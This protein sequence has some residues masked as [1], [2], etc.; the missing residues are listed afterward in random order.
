MESGDLRWMGKGSMIFSPPTR[1]RDRNHHDGN[2]RANRAAC[3]YADC[4]CEAPGRC[5]AVEAILS[6]RCR[7]PLVAF[8]VKDSD[9]T[10]VTICVLGASHELYHWACDGW[11][12][13]V[14]SVVDGHW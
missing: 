4:L 10:I 14:A 7:L 13:I 5:C 3:G 2:G 6:Q 8:G 11:I 9:F 12:H 1:L